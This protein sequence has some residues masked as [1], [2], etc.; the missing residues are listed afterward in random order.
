LFQIS[1]GCL[2]R[3]IS[4]RVFEIESDVGWVR[5]DLIEGFQIRRVLVG[6]DVVKREEASP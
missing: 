6:R 1:T 5:I 4:T 3:R 2:P